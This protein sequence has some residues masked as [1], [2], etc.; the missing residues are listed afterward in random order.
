MNFIKF[1]ADSRTIAREKFVFKVQSAKFK[2]CVAFATALFTG[3]LRYAR[4]D[5]KDVIHITWVP[6]SSTGM[7]SS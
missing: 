4:N 7:T 2:Y 5:K 6:V 3:L 1:Y